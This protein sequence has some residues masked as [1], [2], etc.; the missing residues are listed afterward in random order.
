[1]AEQLANL[2]KNEKGELLD[3]T[4]LTTSV[5]SN[6]YTSIRSIALKANHTYIVCASHQFAVSVA[7]VA[8]VSRLYFGGVQAVVRNSNGMFNGGGVSLSAIVCPTADG[9]ITLDAWQGS[10]E[11]Q[12]LSS[13]KMYAYQLD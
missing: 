3:S 9:S 2:A 4:S 13:I 5:P 10:G 6:T 11:T 12:S 8:T 7:N 1:M